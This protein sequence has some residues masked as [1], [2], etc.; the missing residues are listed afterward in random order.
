[1]GA[2]DEARAGQ[3]GPPEN[4]AVP[5]HLT[6]A[7]LD[8]LVTDPETA[9]ET[10][11]EH[12]LA[13][14]VRCTAGLR[15]RIVAGYREAVAL[16]GRAI[17]EEEAPHTDLLSQVAGRIRAWTLL[18]EAE[19]RSAPGLARE[20]LRLPEAR[21]ID[22]VRQSRRYR[23]LEL[24]RHLSTWARDEVFS[25]PARAVEL[26]R[27]AVEIADRLEA[28]GYP[29]GIAADARALA[30]AAL[31][32][33]RRVG[34]DL[35][36]A[37]R[38]LHTAQEFLEEGSGHPMVRAE[39]ASLLGS[40]RLDQTRFEEAEGVLEEVARVY[41]QHG[42]GRQEAKILLQL[43]RA[44]TDAGNPDLAITFLERVRGALED[45]D[46][47]LRLFASHSLVVALSDAGRI[48]EASELFESIQA[49]YEAHGGDFWMEQRRLWAE[50]RLCLG[51]GRPQEA[52]EAF[53][54]VRE[55]FAEREVA[56]EF[57]LVSLELA[58][59][60]LA[61]GRN[62]EVRRLA[63]ELLPI[64][65]SRQV[66]RHALSGLALFQNAA[67]A[68]RVSSDLVRELHR[69]LQRARN[70]PYLPFTYPAR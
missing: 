40:L 66:H 21:R 30:W 28:G 52:E 22:A 18:L 2:S 70:N 57:A 51:R 27:L 37:E 1:M 48:D 50:A 20:L 19:E 33:A 17:L 10:A 4:L 31:G 12:V 59:M 54:R 62:A 47:R 68:E 26:A 45:G 35:F 67:A 55:G 43:G 25:D 15:K 53:L 60:L 56:Y 42:S 61:Q 7:V 23:S 58:G 5:G 6:D 65:S 64:F 69:Y 14:C 3:A 41:Q 38:A 63:E 46:P 39:V 24:S 16:T 11:R 13:G 32:N 44:A 49:D 9:E 8:R 29:P 36:E 34:S